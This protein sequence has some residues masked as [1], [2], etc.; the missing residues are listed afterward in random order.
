MGRPDHHHLRGHDRYGRWS[1]PAIC[2]NR[3][4]RDDEFMY[5]CGEKIR[6]P[7]LPAVNENGTLNRAHGDDCEPM[8]ERHANRR[9]RL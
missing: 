4:R 8:T 2:R 1:L 5:V 6:F 7:Y 3:R 9:W